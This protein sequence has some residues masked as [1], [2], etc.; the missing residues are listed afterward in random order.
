MG[1]KVSDGKIAEHV[2]VSQPTVSKYRKEFECHSPAL[3]ASSILFA[4]LK[5]G[6]PFGAPV[7]RQFLDSIGFIRR[8]VNHHHTPMSPAC[9]SGDDIDGSNEAGDSNTRTESYILHLFMRNPR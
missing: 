7:P 2:G 6:Q 8:V 1:L 5:I 3:P 9:G 4:W